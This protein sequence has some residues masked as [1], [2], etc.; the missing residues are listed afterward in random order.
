[1]SNW[2]S[3]WWTFGWCEHLFLVGFLVDTS[4]PHPSDPTQVAT[5]HEA[6]EF[7]QWLLASTLHIECLKDLGLRYLNVG[8]VTWKSI[9]QLNNYYRKM[10]TCWNFNGTPKILDPHSDGYWLSLLGACELNKCCSDL[11]GTPL[12]GDQLDCYSWLLA[13]HVH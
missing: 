7:S 2:Q 10:L 11:S 1:M 6:M 4:E 3:G 9:K 12:H 13:T 8:Q 5:F